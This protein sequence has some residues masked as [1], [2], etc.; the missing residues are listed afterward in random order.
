MSK[1]ATRAPVTLCVYSPAEWL[2]LLKEHEPAADPPEWD[3]CDVLDCDSPYMD[4]PLRQSG[5]HNPPLTPLQLPR[6]VS[7][8]APTSHLLIQS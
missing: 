2:H 1:R 5:A 4:S 6:Q 3:M 7:A 8:L